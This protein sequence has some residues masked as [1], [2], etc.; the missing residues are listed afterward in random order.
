MLQH[1]LSMDESNKLPIKDSTKKLATLVTLTTA[2][3]GQS[4]HLK[5]IKGV[6]AEKES[7]YIYD[8]YK[9]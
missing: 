9:P 7:T 6:V 4:I 3:R 2:Q 5:D 1:I 8:Q